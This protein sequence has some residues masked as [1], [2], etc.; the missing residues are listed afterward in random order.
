MKLLLLTLFTTSLLFTQSFYTLSGI[1]SYDTMVINNSKHTKKYKKEIL[2]LMQSMSNEI[3]VDI[4]GEPSTLLY[5][6]VSDIAIGDTLGLRVDL[7]LGEYVLRDNYPNKV[8]GVTYQD[9][10]RLSPDLSDEEDIEDLL[11]DAIEEMLE[12]FKIQYQ[13]DNKENI[14]MLKSVNHESFALDMGYETNYE[15]ALAK[16]KKSHKKLM[17]FMTTSYCPWCRKLENRLLAKDDIDSKI[18]E[19]YIPLMLNLDTD[20][21]PKQFAQ[22]RFTPILYILEPKKETILHKFVGYSSRAAFLTLLK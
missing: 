6:V 15:I 12:K 17:I 8:F 16:A 18:K 7:Q 19:M 9:S 21:Y 10:Q 20:T 5:F 13:D 11:A 2:S 4:T 14:K 22:T 1:I 3:K